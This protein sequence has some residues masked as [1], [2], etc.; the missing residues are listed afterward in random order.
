MSISIVVVTERSS[1]ERAEEDFLDWLVR[2]GRRTGGSIRVVDAAVR[3]PASAT[4]L[5]PLGGV[6]AVVWFVKFRH[7]LRA[8]RFDWRGYSGQRLLLEHDALNNWGWHGRREFCGQWNRVVARDRFDGILTSSR[9]AADRFDREGVN[10]V[11]FPKSYD[12]TRFFDIKQQRHGFCHYG[13]L[14]GARRA[15]LDALQR[16]RFE[17]THV[18]SPYGALNQHLNQFLG[19]IVCNQDA[20]VRRVLRRLLP[21]HPSIWVRARSGIE[22]MYKNFEVA[23]AGAALVCDRVPDLVE[24]GFVDGVSMV[25]YD[26]ASELPERLNTL[27]EEALSSIAEAGSALVAVRHTHE[28]RAA[29]LFELAG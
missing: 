25:A 17:V 22:V 23:G 24:L 28:R 9:T 16:Q 21:G 6:D 5:G 1:V 7:L 11:W 15:L 13:T 12:H 19:C 10:A 2:V 3:W 20:D 8:D 27:S 26:E 14:Y 18:R 29:E 4:D